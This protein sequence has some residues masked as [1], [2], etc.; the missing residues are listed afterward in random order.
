MNNNDLMQKA[1]RNIISSLVGSSFSSSEL[2]EIAEEFSKRQTI[3][4]CIGK[5]LRN[6]VNDV[7]SLTIN[8]KQNQ[9]STKLNSENDLVI[10]ALSVV[11]NKRLSK[12]Q[13]IKLAEDYFPEFN[14]IV[15]LEELT[16]SQ[17]IATL[18][19]QT[20][21]EK[22]NAFLRTLSFGGQQKNYDPYLEGIM[23]KHN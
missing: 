12:Q 5:S 18:F 20:H 1:I 11:K 6:V 4:R 19:N 21:R 22:F 3:S 14:N 10:N 16:M 9:S 7:N 15:G 2:T 17:I 8:S 13:V 23:K